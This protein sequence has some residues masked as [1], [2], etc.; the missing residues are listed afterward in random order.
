M[1]AGLARARPNASG[2][3]TPAVVRCDSGGA[4]APVAAQGA[5]RRRT[6]AHHL[7]IGRAHRWG[8][9]QQATGH[10][11]AGGRGRRARVWPD[12]AIQTH[13]V[14]AD[15]TVEGQGTSHAPRERAPIPARRGTLHK[16]SR[17]GLRAGPAGEGARGA[18]AP[19]ESPPVQTSA[20]TNEARSCGGAGRLSDGA[21]PSGVREASRMSPMRGGK[22]PKLS[23]EAARSATVGGTTAAGSAALSPPAGRASC[24]VVSTAPL[25][26]TSRTTSAMV[27]PRAE[28]PLAPTRVE[29]MP[30]SPASRT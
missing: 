24:A 2:Y 5:S 15:Q 23:A 27:R 25:A 12:A 17:E 11:E 19:A 16:L 21:R 28:R 10:A 7:H 13:A 3:R 26:I 1:H 29:T 6:R 30:E 22:L 4:V 8:E 20:P 14:P 9:S 18:G